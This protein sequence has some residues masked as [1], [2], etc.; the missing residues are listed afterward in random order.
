MARKAQKNAYELTHKN[1]TKS[2]V[3]ANSYNDAINACHTFCVD[4]VQ[5]QRIFSNGTKGKKKNV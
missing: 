5:V 4:A 3:I 2:T 1:G